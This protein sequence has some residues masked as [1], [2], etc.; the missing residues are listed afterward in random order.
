MTDVYAMA[1]ESCN[2]LPNVHYIFVDSDGNEIDIGPDH[3]MYE[4]AK[5]RF[6]GA[7]CE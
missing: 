5:A 1:M 4:E 7:M 6:R 3:P 2:D